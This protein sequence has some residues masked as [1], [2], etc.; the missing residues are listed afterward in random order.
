[1]TAAAYTAPSPVIPDNLRC[2]K[3]APPRGSSDHMVFGCTNPG[4]WVQGLAVDMTPASTVVLEGGRTV[5]EMAGGVSTRPLGE[6]RSPRRLGPLV[7]RDES[8]RESS[9]GRPTDTT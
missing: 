8:H 9:H 6:G 2:E 7:F 3:T 4:P 5:L 1:M